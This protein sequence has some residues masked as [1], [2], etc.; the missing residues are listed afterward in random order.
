LHYIFNFIVSTETLLSEHIFSYESKT[1]EALSDPPS[2]V[3]AIGLSDRVL[4]S[5][6]P[7]SGFKKKTKDLSFSIPSISY[8]VFVSV[9]L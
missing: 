9:L 5:C 4:S 2:R 3:M 8:V 1:Q 7:C 6:F